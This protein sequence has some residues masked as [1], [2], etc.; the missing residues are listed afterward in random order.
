MDIHRE[1]EFVQMTFADTGSG[2]A[3][4][5]LTS[6]FDPFFTTKP[7]GQGTGLGLSVSQGIIKAHGV[8][9]SCESEPGAGTNFIILLPIERSKQNE[10]TNTCN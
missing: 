5:S 2:I 4:E 1:D 9:I 10:K 7:V 6:I 8:Q 3:A